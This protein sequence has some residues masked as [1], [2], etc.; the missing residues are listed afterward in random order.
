MRYA[1]ADMGPAVLLGVSFLSPDGD[2]PEPPQ[3]FVPHESRGAFAKHN[4]PYFDRLVSEGSEQA[5]FVLPRHCNGLGIIHGGMLSAFLDSLLASAAAR[6][7]QAVPVTIHL[8]LDFLDMGRAG[9]W[10]LGEARTTRLTRDLAFVE[11]RAHMQERTLA[12]ASGVFKLMRRR[13]A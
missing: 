12:R 9:D 7:A 13:E 11:G 4:G 2:I 8:S 3:G 10:V 6:A 5:F 1:A